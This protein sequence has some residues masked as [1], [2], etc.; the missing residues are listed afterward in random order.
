MINLGK[1]FKLDI[2]RRSHSPTSTKPKNYTI[3]NSKS[4]LEIAK[5]NPG[6][7]SKT[8]CFAE[9]TGVE[10]VLG[11]VSVGFSSRFQVVILLFRIQLCKHRILKLKCFNC[12]LSSKSE[13]RVGRVIV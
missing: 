10:S 1:S 4:L 3:Q 7:T 5:Q 2:Q 12:C 9:V 8:R 11:E 13:L 6:M